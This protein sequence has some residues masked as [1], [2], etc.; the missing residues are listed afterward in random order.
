MT[1]RRR[2]EPFVRPFFQA[3]ARRMRGFV[4]GVRG[5]VLDDEGRV[6]L[7]EHT[8]INGWYMPGGGVEPGE[9]VEHALTREMLEEAGVE[10]LNRPT[11]LSIHDNRRIFPRDHVLVYRI[12]HWRQVE[13]TQRG[14]IARIGFFAP[15]ALPES[16]TPAT[17]QRLREALEGAEVDLMW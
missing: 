17:R 9:T 8:Y 1:W 5:L 2:I 4:L 7:I 3:Y 14:E 12:N 13:A 6:L 15:D 11:L 16:T 10:I